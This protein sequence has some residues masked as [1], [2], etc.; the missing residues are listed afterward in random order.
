MAINP[1]TN[2]PYSLGYWSSEQEKPKDQRW[3]EWEEKYG[4]A[5]QTDYYADKGLMKVVA[6]VNVVLESDSTD[7]ALIRSQCA[8][9]LKDASWRMIMAKDKAEFDQMWSTMKDNLNGIGFEELYEF[10]CQKYQKV[11]DIRKGN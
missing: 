6:N 11:I 8:Q 10:D 5:K 3:V 4:T 1:I 9:E 2:E 7:M